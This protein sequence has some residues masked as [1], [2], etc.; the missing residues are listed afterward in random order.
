MKK[1]VSRRGFYDEK[2]DLPDYN[3]NYAPIQRRIG[4]AVPMFETTT[5]RKPVEKK[6]ETINEDLYDYNHYVGTNSSV[7]YRR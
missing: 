3:P 7:L 2:E 6:P 5:G 1:T 4:S